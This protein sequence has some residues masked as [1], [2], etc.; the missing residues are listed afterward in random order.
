LTY[1]IIPLL[2]LNR[3]EA[4]VI[5]I[6][7]VLITWRLNKNSAPELQSLFRGMVVSLFIT[8]V[9]LTMFRLFYFGYPLPNTVYAKSTITILGL[10]RLLE[11]LLYLLPFTLLF[12][13][14]FVKNITRRKMEKAEIVFVISFIMMA[15]INCLADAVMNFH[16]RYM[17]PFLPLFIYV[18]V[19]TVFEIKPKI[20]KYAVIVICVLSLFS[21]APA[22]I[23]TIK[24]ERRIIAAQQQVIQSLN[25]K[26]PE[27]R[28]ALTDIGRIPYYNSAAYIDLWGLASHDIAHHGFEPLREFTRFPDYFVLVGY[29]PG[30]LP[31]LRFNH[32]RQ[33]YNFNFFKEIYE[34]DFVGIPVGED[35]ATE[36][37]YYLVFEK[38][39]AKLDS[40]LELYPLN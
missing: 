34:L 33:I 4:V 15:V 11:G 9:L 3:P 8:V 32:E 35:I 27:N 18:A 10:Q 17:V 29:I 25:K 12:I 21:P 13:F 20:L 16:F 22:M 30:G 28:I 31:L 37:Y 39:Q 23:G 26:P 5:V 38:D 14:A 40:L 19:N 2:I 36:G 1:A 7:A 6:A 24:K